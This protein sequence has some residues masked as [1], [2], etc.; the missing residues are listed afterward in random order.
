MR[1]KLEQLIRHLHAETRRLRGKPESIL[2][3]RL[4]LSAQ[5]IYNLKGGG[6]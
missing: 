6:S 4:L 1:T 3:R 5:R 2:V